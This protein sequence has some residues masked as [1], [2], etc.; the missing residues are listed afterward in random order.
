MGLKIGIM[1]GSF[2]PIHNMHL[3]MG[4]MAYE[5]FG[6]DKVLIMPLKT[7]YFD[8]KKL[9]SGIK[10]EDRVSMIK[11]AIAANPHFEFSDLELKR[12]GVTYTVDTLESLHASAP[13]NEYYFICGA[14]SLFGLER[15]YRA[16]RIMELATIIAA[17]RDDANDKIDGQVE[18]LNQKYQARIF[19][20]DSP[21]LEISSSYIRNRVGEGKSCRYLVPDSVYDYIKEHNLYE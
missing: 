11:R 6:L 4:E 16:E 17:S 10:D 1:G 21:N 8:N 14:D 3:L 12:E 15:W 18:Y 2:N 19:K 9:S 7:P 5:E 20:L 13:E